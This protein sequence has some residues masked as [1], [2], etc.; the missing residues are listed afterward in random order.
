MFL[1]LAP[2]ELS[3][4]GISKL[5]LVASGWRFGMLDVDLSDVVLLPAPSALP[6]HNAPDASSATPS[7]LLRRKARGAALAV[8]NTRAA[9]A[10]CGGPLLQPVSASALLAMQPGALLV[11]LVVVVVV[12]A[13][14]LLLSVS[15]GSGVVP[16]A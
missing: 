12:V 9:V 10:P 4:F 14:L 1:G 6:P 15:T 5:S 7:G 8:P 16:R 3:A 2:F 13:V 11:V